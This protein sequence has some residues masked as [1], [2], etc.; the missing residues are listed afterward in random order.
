MKFNPQIC[1]ASVKTV[2]REMDFGNAVV[3]IEANKTFFFFFFCGPSEA[4]SMNVMLLTF[5][6]LQEAFFWSPKKEEGQAE[7]PCAGW[8]CALP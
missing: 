4:G 1:P 5:L 7:T 2:R 8:V 3:S 6:L